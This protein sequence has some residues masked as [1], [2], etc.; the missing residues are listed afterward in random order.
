[1]FLNPIKHVKYNFTYDFFQK[2]LINPFYE[3]LVNLT[4]NKVVLNKDFN[5]KCLKRNTIHEVIFIPSF[6]SLSLNSLNVHYKVVKSKRINNYLINLDGYSN[7]N[8]YLKSVMTP[9]HIKQ[10]RS[11]N[12]RLKTCFNISYKSYFGEISESDY[13]FLFNKLKKLIERRF[14][15]RGDNFFLEDKWDYLIENTFQLILEKKVSFF[16]I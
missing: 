8:E 13:K 1:M 9:K 12:R 11:R 5:T 10:L 7:S 15:Q 14:R 2:S 16:V 4:N 6:F 3:S